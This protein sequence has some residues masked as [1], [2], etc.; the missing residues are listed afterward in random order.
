MLVSLDCEFELLN[1]LNRSTYAP[2][3][4]EDEVVVRGARKPRERSGRVLVGR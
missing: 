3:S 1:E 4:D 2:A